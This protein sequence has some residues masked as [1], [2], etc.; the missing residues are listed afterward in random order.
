[1]P[2]LVKGG[3][4]VYGWVVVGPG[5]TLPIPPRRLAQVLIRAKRLCRV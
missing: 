2:R 1:M 5:L 3:K 4:W